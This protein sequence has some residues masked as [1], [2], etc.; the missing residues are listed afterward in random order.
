M[1]I[2]VVFS[3]Y[4]GLGNS[5]GVKAKHGLKLFVVEISGEIYIKR[6]SALFTHFCFEGLYFGSSGFP[7]RLALLIFICI[8]VML[9]ILGSKLGE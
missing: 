2:M 4:C 7:V 1:N 3:K 5:R 9:V 6:E 8:P